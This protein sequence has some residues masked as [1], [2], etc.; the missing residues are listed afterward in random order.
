MK[1][2]ELLKIVREEIQSVVKEYGMESLYFTPGG[3]EQ[4]G[5]RPEPARIQRFSTYET[6]EVAAKQHGAIVQDRG[7]DWIAVM[8]N[9]DKLGTFSKINRIGTL[10]L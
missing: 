4:M 6:W 5:Q 1:R 3:F 8:P 10:S 2:S 7:E 9:Q